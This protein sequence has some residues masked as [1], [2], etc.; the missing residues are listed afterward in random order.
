VRSPRWAAVVVN[1][2]AG[3]LLLDSVRSLLADTS[4][5][6]P[7]AV[8][9]VDNASTDDSVTTLRA[10]VPSVA[11]VETGRN[12]G[13]AAA[14]NRGIARTDAPVVAVCNADVRVQ[15]GA[16]AALLRR[17]DAEP[18]LAA[19]GPA[20]VEPDGT[21]YPSARRVVSAAD[22]VGHGTL[23]RVW[24]GNPY[25]RRYRQLDA[26]PDQ[27]RDVDWVSGAAVWLR[28]AALD[29]VGGWDER[30]FMYVEDVDLC[31]RLRR[32][33]W[34]VG[35][36]PAAT[37]V[38]VQGASTARHPYR[39]IAAHHRSLL[40]F[41]ARRWRGWRRALLAPAAVYLGARAGC[42]MLAHAVHPRS[43]RRG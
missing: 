16:G 9:V 4:A 40:R 29:A 1:Y 20:I 25:T 23:V 39:M 14:A 10:A 37:V 43:G 12:L 30:Y 36:E 2:E 21:R 38:H 35:F 33:G 3:P 8:V 11:V 15:P 24:P 22:A 34:R 31:W 42:S 27:P 6:G 7:P 26:D 18:D 17:L 5:G 13:Y 41:A 28:R 19:V 32:G